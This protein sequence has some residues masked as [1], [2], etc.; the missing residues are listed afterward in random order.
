MPSGCQMVSLCFLKSCLLSFPGERGMGAGRLVLA[1]L[2]LLSPHRFVL[3]PSSA[4]CSLAGLRSSCGLPKPTLG[5]QSRLRVHTSHG[6]WRSDGVDHVVSP[7]GHGAATVPGQAGAGQRQAEGDRCS[8][9]KN[10]LCWL[11]LAQA[12]WLCGPCA[13][14]WL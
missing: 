2:F 12:G 4:L 7:R 8:C 3:H 13:D 1:L 14:H 10:K 9:A 5:K 6:H 11:C